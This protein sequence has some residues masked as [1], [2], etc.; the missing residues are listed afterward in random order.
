M[1][2]EF[3]KNWSDF[4]VSSF[5]E[6]KLK[7]ASS[8]MLGFLGSSSLEGK[9]FLDIGCGSGIHSLAAFLA[10]AESVTS[11][12]FDGKSVEATKSIRNL[13]GDPKNWTV[14]EGSILDTKFISQLGQYDIVYSWGVLHHTGDMWTAIKAAHGLMNKNALFYIVLYSKEVFVNPSPEYWLKLKR[15]YK[16]CIRNKEFLLIRIRLLR[17]VYLRKYLHKEIL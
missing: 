10:G 14:L 11:F 6:D 8:H 3:G 16:K 12:D 9:R 7:N 15:K 5:S 2:Y 13:Y 4:V 1:R 17:L